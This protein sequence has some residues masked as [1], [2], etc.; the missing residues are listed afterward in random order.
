M[1]SNNK[2]GISPQLTL[3]TQFGLKNLYPIDNNCVSTRY[4]NTPRPVTPPPQTI[5][6][7]LLQEP[8]P[9]DIKILDD[10]LDI[11]DVPKEL[12]SDF[13]SWVQSVHQYQR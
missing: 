8:E 1:D 5:Q 13:D 11:I 2:R 12:F 7:E 10:L 3:M 6:E 9:M 4:C